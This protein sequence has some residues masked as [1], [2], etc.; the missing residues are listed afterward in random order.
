MFPVKSRSQ[1]HKYNLTLSAEKKNVNSNASGWSR[2]RPSF[3]AVS[4]PATADRYFKLTLSWLVFCFFFFPSSMFSL[5][6]WWVSKKRAVSLTVFSTYWDRW[7]LP[8]YR[9]TRPPPPTPCHRRPHHPLRT[10]L[11]WNN[12]RLFCTGP[13]HSAWPAPAGGRVCGLV[14]KLRPCVFNPWPLLLLCIGYQL[15]A[16][17]H[18]LK[19]QCLRVR[20]GIDAHNVQAIQRECALLHQTNYC[21]SSSLIFNKHSP[22]TFGSHFN[23]RVYKI[24]QC[25]L[26][27]PQL[28]LGRNLALFAHLLLNIYL[29]WSH[30]A[31]H[32]ATVSRRP[33]E[34][35]HFIV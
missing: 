5:I 16:Q 24:W 29:L 21:I 23:P 20:R 8:S 13:T 4:K 9:A 32:K 25:L 33:H 2:R 34:I 11:A 1:I 30:K 15:S 7:I 28:S 19:W 10:L 26:F 17:M 31:K 14:G 18:N 12:A 6:A 22:Q 27:D 3:L 35:L